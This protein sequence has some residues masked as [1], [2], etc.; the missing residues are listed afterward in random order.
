[1]SICC[2]EFTLELALQYKDNFSHF[3]C[4]YIMSRAQK[5]IY[6]TYTYVSYIKLMLPNH[7]V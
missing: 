1:M 7:N 6:S 5:H 3:I 2:Y 4:A